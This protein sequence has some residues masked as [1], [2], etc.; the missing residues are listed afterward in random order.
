MTAPA[1]VGKKGIP[2]EGAQRGQRLARTRRRPVTGGQDT[3]PLGRR[4]ATGP[5]SRLGVRKSH[6]SIVPGKRGK[7]TAAPGTTVFRGR[8]P[9]PLSLARWPVRAY[10][11]SPLTPHR[12]GAHGRTQ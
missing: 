8:S 7:R 1:G 9:L 11:I 5:G 12:G 4:K 6:A 2:V 10:R 3:A